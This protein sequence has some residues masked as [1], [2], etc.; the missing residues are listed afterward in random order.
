MKKIIIGFLFLIFTVVCSSV[1][2]A[3]AVGDGFSAPKNLELDDCEI[4]SWNEVKN[5]TSYIVSVNDEE[6]ATEETRYDL[7][8]VMD[9]IGEY[10][11]SVTAL[12][13]GESV[14]FSSPSKTLKYEV[15]DYS[16]YLDIDMPTGHF[17]GICAV[18]KD[19]IAGKLVF[20][21]SLTQQAS[22]NRIAAEGF[23]GC[24]NL[25][26]VIFPEG[27]GW[28]YRG[29]FQ[30]CT[31]LKRVR[32]E[33]GT[34]REY[35]FDGCTN[36][37][38]VTLEEGITQLSG[39]NIFANTAAEEIY[40]PSSVETI[41]DSGFAYSAVRKISVS[42]FNQNYSSENGCLLEKIKPDNGDTRYRL[43]FC[44][45][46]AEIPDCV[47]EIGSGAFVGREDLTEFV[48]PE[49][50]EEIHSGFFAG[51]KNLKTVTVDRDNSVFKGEGN[52][53]IRKEDNVL[54]Q[55]CIGSVIPDYVTVI[56]DSAFRGTD[57]ESLTVPE[58]ITEIGAGAFGGC[59]S[60]REV[61]FPEAIE[62]IGEW[63]FSGC[64]ALSEIKLPEGIESIGANAFSGCTALSEIRL[65]EGLKSIG[66]GC[67]VNCSSLLSVVIPLSADL[68][69]V[70]FDNC[71]VYL[72]KNSNYLGGMLSSWG[73][74][75][76]RFYGCEF[77]YDGK[78]PYVSSIRY[79]HSISSAGF[80]TRSI[81]LKTQ[82]RIIPK[83]EGYTFAKWT[84][85]RDDELMDLTPQKL[86]LQDGEADVCFTN[87]DL[88][89]LGVTD[90][91]TLT[92]VWIKN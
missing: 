92:A 42:G 29:A 76:N 68:G 28:I 6:F 79:K 74:S 9:E 91:I 86:I 18:D 35:A 59:L 7:F 15:K 30:D 54:V 73:E 25:A 61:I 71:S 23:K 10:E 64:T 49:Q 20:P 19:K 75:C 53:I 22:G 21:E 63:A 40:I 72:H 87:D 24:S 62:S 78:Y 55:G 38:D 4:L 67:F 89:K 88:N 41:S 17:T 31:S 2:A 47:T 52:C 26:G 85:E 12:K 5:A 3:C 82:L 56:G 11:I 8:F 39:S 65:P 46:Q 45:S 34:I 32:I 58:N 1:A 50:I 37:Y 16:E 57:F 44:G 84:G 69:L 27:I 14:R 43:L 90:G 13:R 83:R 70:V 36:L 80:V 60:L 77:G 81:T 33:K 51:C 48:M 66:D